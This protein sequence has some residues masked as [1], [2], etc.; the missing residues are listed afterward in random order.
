VEAENTFRDLAS[1]MGAF[2]QG[3]RIAAWIVKHAC[4]YDAAKASGALIAYSNEIGT[5]G[6]MRV[7]SKAQVAKL[8][9]IQIS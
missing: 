3:E 6:K 9:R 1:Q 4:R 7:S 5:A 2:S 8:L